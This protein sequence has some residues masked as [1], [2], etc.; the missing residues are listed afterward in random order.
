MR[1]DGRFCSSPASTTGGVQPVWRHDGKELFFLAPDNTL[2]ALPVKF[3]ASSPEFG[4]PVALFK[5]A[6]NADPLSTADSAVRPCH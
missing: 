3:T 5:H 2:M 4:A 6:T 1:S